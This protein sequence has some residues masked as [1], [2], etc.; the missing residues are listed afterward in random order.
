MLDRRLQQPVDGEHA[1][2]CEQAADDHRPA[3]PSR[4]RPGAGELAADDHRDRHRE[5]LERDLRAGELRDD[6][7]VERGEEEDRKQAEAG[8]EGDE[9]GDREGGEAEELEPEHRVAAAALD[10][11]EGERR[12]RRRRRRAATI[13]QAPKPAL[14]PSITRE[15]ERGDRGRPGD[16]AGQVDRAACG[17][18]ALLE[19]PRGGDERDHAEREV[20]PE[21]AAPAGRSRRAGRRAPARRRARCP[22][23]T[24][25]S[26][27][28]ARAP[29]RPGRAGG[30]ATASPAREAAAPTPITTRPAISVCV[31]AAS[32]AISAPRQKSATPAS[33][34]FLRPEDVARAC[35]R[36]S[37]S[38]AKARM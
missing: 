32:A 2:P 4:G 24:S 23:R 28:P 6:L 35:R 18:G 19:R 10:R 38:A 21:D 16:E 9:V 11:D 7:Q 20:E 8:R 33:S 36:V 14:S 31:S 1:A 3:R 5:K 30:S 12:E 27:A 26:R 29:A 37:I 13:H 25:R 17:I 22:R 15:G 34:T